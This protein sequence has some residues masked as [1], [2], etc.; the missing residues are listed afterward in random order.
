MTAAA[1]PDRHRVTLHVS[2]L[3]I[4]SIFEV[5]GSPTEPEDKRI[6]TNN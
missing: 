3:I 6:K 1:D 5:Y 2:D 4:G